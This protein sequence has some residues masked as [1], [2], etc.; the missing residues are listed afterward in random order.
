[1]SEIDYLNDELLLT[2]EDKPKAAPTPIIDRAVEV[3]QR[4]EAFVTETGSEPVSEPGRSVR[5]RILANELA[6]LRASRKELQELLAFDT[7]GLVFGTAK[8][9]DPLSDPLLDDPLGIFDVRDELK[10]I[11]RPDYV[12]DRRPCPDF[13]RFESLF[14]QV[15]KSVENGSRKPQPFR[16]ERVELGE[17]FALKG[18]LVHVAD[19]R[20]EHRRNGKPDARLRVIF[21]NGLESNL[22]MSSLVRRLYEDKD[23]R[24]IGTTDAGPLFEGARTG[25]VYVLRSLSNKPEVSGLLKVGTT[26]GGVEDRVS[27]A[28]AQ[29]AFLFAPVEVVE[30]F[31]LYGHSAKEAEKRIHEALRSYHVALRVIGPDGRSFSATEWFKATPT[32]I[33]AAV[34]KALN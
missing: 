3:L 5:E 12:A 1:M 16:Q 4:I 31:E 23:A 24:R 20:D 9:D 13:E 32:L 2:P 6:G 28:E 18:Q 10:P 19:V 26:A 22:L 33:E 27:R 15:R 25:I 30:T 17:F 7:Q 34:R 8:A 21:D 14:E 11:A 29:S